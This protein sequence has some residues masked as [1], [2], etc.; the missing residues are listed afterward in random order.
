MG[1]RREEI[2]DNSKGGGTPTN[3]IHLLFVMVLCSIMKACVI[4]V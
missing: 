4:E 3:K 2:A 1:Y